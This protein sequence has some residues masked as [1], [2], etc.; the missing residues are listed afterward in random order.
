MLIRIG[1]WWT[2]ATRTSAHSNVI[3]LARTM[4]GLATLGTLLADPSRILFVATDPKVS[5]LAAQ[6]T[7]ASGLG[8]FCVLPSVAGAQWLAIGVLLLVVVGWR[9]RWTALPHWYI[10]FSLQANATVIDGGDQITAVVTLLLIPICLADGRRWHWDKPSVGEVA[11]LPYVGR[12]V[13]LVFLFLIQCQ[14]GLL[15]FDAGVAKFG[16]QQWA[17]G[18]AMYYWLHDP[19][20]GLN[21]WQLWLFRPVLEHGLLLTAFTWSVVLGEV[22]LGVGVL[23]P[24]RRRKP[25]L[26]AALVFHC[27]IALLMGLVTFGLSMMAV[28][29][30]AYRDVHDEFSFGLIRRAVRRWRPKPGEGRP[31]ADPAA[32]A[33]TPAVVG[34]AEV[35]SDH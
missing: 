11:G 20:F 31:S 30:L 15:Y 24:W 14:V 23:L 7:G 19:T 10:A 26:A 12:F 18:T 35:L 2:A 33:D 25:L 13:T 29:I 28:D 22:L 34:A 3:G 17:D 21:S 1:A 27:G 9:P 5:G 6:C 4:L 32:R 16:V 8:L